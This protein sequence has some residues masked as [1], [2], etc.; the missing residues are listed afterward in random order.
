MPEWF[1]TQKPHLESSWEALEA[2]LGETCY[3]QVTGGKSVPWQGTD[4]QRPLG[5]ICKEYL[6]NFTV[7][8]TSNLLSRGHL[9]GVSHNTFK[10]HFLCLHLVRVEPGNTLVP[11]F[12]W[13]DICAHLFLGTEFL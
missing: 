7:P 2:T 4:R 3:E 5:T 12:P 13:N 10:A 1:L 6:D 9:L 11:V 8:L